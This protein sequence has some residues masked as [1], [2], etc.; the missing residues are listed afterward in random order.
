MFFG[1]QRLKAL[2]K[3]C[4]ITVCLKAYPDTSLIS[5]A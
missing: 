4:R 1:A 3:G 2:C 5:S